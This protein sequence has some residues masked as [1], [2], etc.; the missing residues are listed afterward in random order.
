MKNDNTLT[1]GLYVIND[2]IADE[3]SPVFEAKNEA[4]AL[5]QYRGLLSKESVFPEEYRLFQVGN[6]NKSTHVL[7]A[8][9][10]VEIL[11]NINTEDN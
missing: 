4:I 5:R 11:Y 8:M 1:M 2:K 6:I 10:P 7:T 3:D 9:K